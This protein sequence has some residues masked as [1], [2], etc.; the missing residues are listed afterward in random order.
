MSSVHCWTNSDC[1]ELLWLDCSWCSQVQELPVW[2]FLCT[3]LTNLDCNLHALRP[4]NLHTGVL[5]ENLATIL[6]ESYTICSWLSSRSCRTFSLPGLRIRWSWVVWQL[7]C[8]RCWDPVWCP[9]LIILILIG[10]TL[11]KN[12]LKKNLSNFKYSEAIYDN[13]IQ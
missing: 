2:V 3:P 12:C 11:N 13:V 1:F 10:L 4:F 8:V 7:G 5:H 6:S 9:L